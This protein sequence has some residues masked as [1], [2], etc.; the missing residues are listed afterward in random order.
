[1]A[2]MK[3]K[4][5]G[6]GIRALLSSTNSD[7]NDG[8]DLLI[9]ELSNTIANIPLS[10]IEINPYQPRS[11]FDVDALEQ[12]AKSIKIHGL[13]QPITVRRLAAGSFQIIS[14]ERRVRACR[15]NGMKDIPAYVRIADDQGMLE[16]ALIENIQRQDLN[17]L[18]VAF[19][20]QRLM[21]ECD[22]THEEVAERVSKNRSTVSN[23][24]RLL[25]LPPAVQNAVR[26]EK[27]S[28][29]H[30]RAIAGV[31]ELA[32]QL[33]ILTSIIEQSWSVRQVEQFIKRLRSGGSSS[34]A[35]A[36]S[37]QKSTDVQRLQDEM[38]GVFGTKV[39]LTSNK[40]GRGKL[41]I[42]FDDHDELQ[43]IIQLVRS[44]D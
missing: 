19:S 33:H 18:E 30:A 22:I 36:G 17:P 29:G 34:S 20:Y 6:K 3:K 25:K 32:N 13:V 28:M 10:E 9:K 31:D 21:E 15:M 24:I 42:H 23:Y 11:E 1:M 12:L 14:G 27:I 8:N 37:I 35:S 38:S 40:E 5:L 7:A 4:D 39:N 44:V 41:V 43:H 16:M 26:Q 2:K